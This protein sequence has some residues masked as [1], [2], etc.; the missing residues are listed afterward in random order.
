MTAV[1]DTLDRRFRDAASEAGLL[2]VSYDV[3]ESPVG[4]LF[5]ART[6]RGLCRISYDPEP[7]R[8][9][10]E[11]ARIFG[12]RVLRAPKAVDP[13]VRELDEYFEGRRQSFDLPVDLRGR[14]DFSRAVLEKLARVPFGE[15]TTYGALAAQAGRPRAARAVGTVMNRNPI[16]IVLPC[17]RVIG[18]SGDLVGYGGGLDRKRLLLDLESADLR[19][20]IGKQ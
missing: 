18:A 8:L 17:H 20:D 19:L 16:P 14:A 1:P 5:V 3:T 2:D 9:T 6:D 12:A 11:L 15:V 7:E 13:V 10:E 4:Q